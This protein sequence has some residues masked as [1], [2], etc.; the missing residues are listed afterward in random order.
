MGLPDIEI[1]STGTAG[2]LIAFT[3][4]KRRHPD[5]RTV[6]V[7]GYTCPLVVIAAAAAGL[8]AV[9]CD[10]IA[11]GFDLDADHL[12]RLVDA[13]TLAVAPTHY[14]GALSDIGRVRAVATA[15]SPDIAIVEDAAQAFGATWHGAPVGLA[16]DIGV[17]SF[18]AGK[19]FTIYEG[20]ALV[21]RDAGI[22]AGLRQ[23]A[24]EMTSSSALGEVWRGVLL[25]GYHALYNPLGLRIAY[26][27]QKRFWL[28]RSDEF[29][30]AGDKFAM[31]IAVNRVGAWRKRVGCAALPRL[32]AHQAHSR[33]RFDHLARRLAA[34]P[35]LKVHIPF[36]GTMPTA[37]FLFVTL[38]A[39]LRSHAII[40]ALWRS[41]LGIAKMFSHAI[42]DYP[43]LVPL[44][45]RS[46]TPNA[47]ALA[48]TTVTLSTDD[49]L[50][51]AAE[52]VIL[53][54]LERGVK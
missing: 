51:S 19:G 34:I 17:F 32:P 4:L 54:T 7:P 2:L 1:V 43:D 22:M 50:S 26:G 53:Q 30:A 3:F 47:R 15:A 12:A 49:T 42:G 38:P 8:E 31:S 45:H 25:V 14:G 24:A 6:I 44:L 39:T 23:V 13:R 18:G 27:A 48:A 37:T 46:E 9:A 16:G 5:R 20:G 33:S 11:G 29:R 28:A 21:A 40:Q 41:R 10:T 36:P 52:A 35:G